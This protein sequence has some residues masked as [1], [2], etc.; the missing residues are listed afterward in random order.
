MSCQTGIKTAVENYVTGKPYLKFNGKNFIEVLTSPKEKVNPTNYYGVAESV[1]N[2]LNKA[3]N[4]DLNLGKVF[5]PK[6]YSNGV[7]VEIAPTERQLNLLNAQ[8]ENEIKEALAALDEEIAPETRLDLENDTAFGVNAEG[9]S[10]ILLQ[11]GEIPASKASAQTVSLAKDLLNRMGVNLQFVKQIVVDGIKMDAN[12]VADMTQKLVQ[13]VEDK[14]DVALTEEVMHFAVEIIAQ[15]DPQLFN[16]LLK[17]I[18]NYRIYNEVLATYS[19]NKAYQTA[20]GKP[21]ILKLKKE[22]IGK[23]L[24]ETVINKNEGSIE[25]PENLAKVEN[26]WSRMISAIKGLFI[27]SGFDQAAMKVLSGEE[28]GTVDDIRDAEGLFFQQTNETQDSVINKLK[29]T[30]NQITKDDTGYLINGKRIKQRVTELIKSWYQNRFAD[31]DLT[32]TEFQQAVDDLKAEKG[33]AGHADIENML[34]D[35]FLA[36]D[37]TLLPEDQ[38]PDDSGYVSQLDPKNKD[39]YNILKRN[40]A[41]RLASFP[42]GTKFLSEMMVY[43]AKRD[44]AGTIDFIAVTPEGK[45]SLLD[46][47]FMDLNVE[48]YEDVPWY[49]VNAWRQQMKQYKLILQNAYGVKPENFDQTRMIPIKAIYSKGDAKLNI[50][51]T[52][53]GINIG[54]VDVKKEELAYLL[55]VG[56]EEE[57]TGN[58]K[59]DALIEKLNKIYETISSK[60][61]TPEE[62]RNK[63]DQLNALYDAI[64]QLQ[65]RQNI[66]PLV[67]Q[68]KLLNAEVQRIIDDY[69][70][71]WEGKDPKSFT[72]EQKNDFSDRILSYETSLMVYTSLSTD[73]KT[74]FKG[75]LSEEDEKLWK[76]I[77]ETTEN[78]N[79]LESDLEDVRNEFA[80]NVIAKSLNVLDFL[81]PEKVIKGFSKWFSSTSTLQL[82]ATEILYKMANNAFG[83]AAMDTQTEGKKLQNLKANFDKWAKGKGLTNKN[84][85]DILKKKDKNELIDEFNPEFY[86]TLKSKIA[87][88]DRQWVRENIDVAAYNDFLKEQR[89]KEYKRIDDKPRFGT[90]EEINN[91]IKREKFNSDKLYDTSTTD[92][93]GWL[94]YDFVRRFPI[95]DK[96]ES[97]EWKELNNPANKPALDFYNYIKERNEYFEQIGYINKARTFLPFVRKS[98]MEKIVMGGNVTV[99]ESLL[100]AVTVSEGD[101]GY[102][103]IDPITKEPVYSIPKYFTRETGEEVSEDLFRNMTLLNE[104]GIRYSYLINIEKQMNNII[105]VEG[106]KE[107]IKTSYFGKTKYKT[108]GTIETTSDNSDNTQLVR[109]MMEAIIYGHKYVESENFDQLLGGLGNFGKRANEKLGMKVFPEQFDNAQISLNKT[110]TQL[111]TIFQIKTLGLNPISALSNFLGGS[112]QS[113]INAGTYFTKA[114]FMRNEF[115]IAGKMRGA[116]AKKYIGALEYF[117]PLTE[118]YNQQI[119][120][121]LSLSK[122]SQEGV[123]D[124]LMSLMRNSDQY[125]QS[126]NFFSYLENS[127]VQDGEIVNAREFLRAT[128]EY[129][130]IYNVSA[131]ERK[132]LEKKF[133]E[134]VKKLIEDK[135]VMKLAEVKGDELVIPGLERK[136]ESVIA[137]RRKVQSLTKDALGN[138]SEDDIRK[139]NLNIYGKSF[140][141]FKN[142]IP[143]LVDVRAGNLKYNSANESYEWGRTRMMIRVISED[144]LG[145]IGNLTNSLEANEKGVEF[146]REMYEKKKADYEKETGKTL[147]MTEAEFMDLFRK[148]I[149]NQMTDV[150]FYLALTMLIIGAKAAGPGDDDDRATKNRYKFMLRIMDKVR[151]EIAYFYDPTSLINLTTTGIFPSIS[152]INNFKK[153]FSNFLTEMYAI[154]VN[155]EDLQKKNQVIKYGLKGFP[156]TSQF[157]SILLMFFPD[158][159]KDLGM[160]AQ[161]EAKPLG[162]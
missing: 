40:L 148:N 32:K 9:D 129:A 149:K 36:E 17:E 97:K 126:V 33:T 116:D 85:F 74:L 28:I 161:S 2:T 122:L 76:D 44:L 59:I 147:N 51:P 96:W 84:Y 22:A 135:G 140:M 67:R 55:P 61:A 98:L 151:D 104:M 62:K 81:K 25:K 160:K 131:E 153:L 63:A 102:G 6:T 108:D 80:E 89:Q 5:Y 150:L 105:R 57:K 8:E 142:W 73:L 43:D 143:R 54:N 41:D 155:D 138:M 23:V 66:K 156:I 90:E 146:M 60:K 112:F 14:E 92:A 128:P 39:M 68:A 95:R 27:K 121:N 103:Q 42:A 56:L 137:L 110:I 132:A 53:T 78:A 34:K 94:L 1:A 134:D 21:D 162:Q 4:S 19:K 157:D 154:G 69:R 82:K 152:Y 124:F 111:N 79:E 52:L 11:T 158:I 93:P 77:R 114:D 49:K 45:V 15:K 64:R 65:V 99:G 123:Q 29:E 50:K 130:N 115:L 30:S 58:K 159:A 83:L 3:I 47:K 113:Y 117:L 145:S 24:A 70:N 37:G 141:I 119:A 101:V 91:E 125:V 46:W 20:D 26:W 7:G 88:K 118:N 35:H 18:N 16:T 10:Q 31:K 136:S 48:K 71:N 120:K 75:T 109:D 106:N 127:I 100:R 144:L 107:A 72:E 87:D 38:R 86:Q 13:V 133:E 139:I 12:G